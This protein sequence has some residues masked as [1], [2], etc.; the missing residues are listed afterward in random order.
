M[1]DCWKIEELPDGKGKPPTDNPEVFARVMSYNLLGDIVNPQQYIRARK[2]LES[3]IDVTSQYLK[4]TEP[5]PKINIHSLPELIPVSSSMSDTSS[6]TSQTESEYHTACTYL[7]NQSP[8]LSDD[9]TS[10]PTSDTE[11]SVTESTNMPYHNQHLFPGPVRNTCPHHTPS[12]PTAPHH[13]KTEV[14]DLE[15]LALDHPKIHDALKVAITTTIP[16]LGH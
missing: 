12:P 6:P 11:S 8:P 3:L 14:T 7:S 16:Q 4:T 13:T 15:E 5:D 9:D 2:V 1:M 10:W